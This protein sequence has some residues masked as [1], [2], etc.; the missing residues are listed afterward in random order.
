MVRYS[1]YWLVGIT[2]DCKRQK[3]NQRTAAYF[4]DFLKYK[5]FYSIE[6][7]NLILEQKDENIIQ[8]DL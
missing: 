6:L 5:R 8:D 1:V 4:L 2:Y 3:D 7:L